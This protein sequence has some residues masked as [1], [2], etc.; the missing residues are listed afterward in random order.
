MSFFTIHSCVS[1]SLA[2]YDCLDAAHQ[3]RGAEPA[4]KPYPNLSKEDVQ[5]LVDYLV[6]RKSKTDK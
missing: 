6:T 4:M 1:P 2:R 5:A 3:V